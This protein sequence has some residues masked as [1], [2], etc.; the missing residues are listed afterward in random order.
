M[1]SA[2]TLH[3]AYFE[4]RFARAEDWENWPEEFAIITGYATTG[5]DWPQARNDA[6]DRELAAFLRTHGGWMKRLTG[7]SP[8][9][10]HS[11][12]GWAVE[13]DFESACDV[14]RRFRQDAIYWVTGDQL[15][16]SRCDASRQ[17]VPVGPFRE[18]VTREETG[19]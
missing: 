19:S 3:P 17:P 9:T 12:P 2:P 10:G 18:R 8:T 11:E 5:E 16:V 1:S 14:G 4:T 15:W 13:M 7:Y 6:A